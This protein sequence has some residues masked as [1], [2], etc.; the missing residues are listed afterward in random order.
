[1]CVVTYVR[2]LG[3]NTFILKEDHQLRLRPG[4]EA[5]L[6]KLDRVQSESFH[7]GVKKPARRARRGPVPWV[8]RCWP[9]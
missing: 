9:Q 2:F 6:R 4:R 5:S 7:T 1:M 8:G 3:K